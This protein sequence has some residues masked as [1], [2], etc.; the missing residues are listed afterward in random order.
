M[1]L[2][3]SNLFAFEIH[4]RLLINSTVCSVFC[5]LCLFVCLFFVFLCEWLYSEYCNGTDHVY[6]YSQSYSSGLNSSQVSYLKKLL[7]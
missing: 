2:D 1:W 4:S 6:H 3:F 7:W 5:S